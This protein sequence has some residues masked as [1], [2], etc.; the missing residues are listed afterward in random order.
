MYGNGTYFRKKETEINQRILV[1]KMFIS[2]RFGYI[3]IHDYTDTN[4]RIETKMPHIAAH[5]EY[6]KIFAYI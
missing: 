1:L 4:T 2:D 3:H 5:R 6:I